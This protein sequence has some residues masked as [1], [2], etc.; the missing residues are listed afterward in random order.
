MNDYI[1]VDQMIDNWKRIGMSKEE[2]VIAVAQACMGWPY[3]FGAWGE[4]CTP[5]NRKRRSRDDHPTIVSK[6][7]VLKGKKS[8]CASC[9]WYPGGVSVR[10]YDCRGF[11]D[12]VLKVSGVI[13]LQGEGATSQWNAASNW[14][15]KGLIADMPRDRVCCLFK[16]D[17]STGK[18]EHTGLWLKNDMIIHCSAGVQTGKLKGFTHYAVPAGMYDDMA[19]TPME[20]RPTLRRGSNGDSVRELQEILDRLG[21]DLGK[22]GIDSDFGRATEKAV[23]AFQKNAGI[24]VDGIV[25][26]A[27]W[28]ALDLTKDQYAKP[29]DPETELYTVVIQHLCKEAAEALAASHDGTQIVKEGVS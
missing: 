9:G 21:Y 11:T 23:K 5:A 22:C 12:W 13:D 19:G 20:R 26:A 7:Q 3:V 18:M 6:C 2:I 16:L 24:G 17:K 10:C 15:Q 29:S 14:A 28:A 8:T 1:Q 27:T 25:G 4:L